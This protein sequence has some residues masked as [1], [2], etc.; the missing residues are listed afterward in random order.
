MRV[1]GLARYELWLKMLNL[2]AK[3]TYLWLEISNLWAKIPNLYWSYPVMQ[4]QV[5]GFLVLLY[6]KYR[7]KMVNFKQLQILIFKNK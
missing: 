1:Q 4:S 2:W 7:Q 6:Q 3:I 5:S